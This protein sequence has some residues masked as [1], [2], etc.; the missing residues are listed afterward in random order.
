[1]IEK[2]NQ[3]NVLSIMLLIA[4][5]S[6]LLL[7]I[8]LFKKNDLGGYLKMKNKIPTRDNDK[9]I[10][11]I[12]DIKPVE[13]SRKEK[14]TVREKRHVPKRVEN[15]DKEGDLETDFLASNYDNEGS[16]ETKPLIEEDPP[17]EFL[18]QEG[19]DETGILSEEDKNKLLEDN[20]NK[21][22]DDRVWGRPENNFITDKEG[23]VVEIH[24]SRKISD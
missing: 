23:E 21:H 7:S 3:L 12:E 8:Y 16:M 6:L 19:D 10:D 11:I 15:P 4:G 9:N 22:E 13:P 20:K 5:I 18:L 17:T 2:I 24:G 14:P 1:M